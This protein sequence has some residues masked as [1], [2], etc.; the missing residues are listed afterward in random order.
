M[1]TLFV[2]HLE[3]LADGLKEDVTFHPE[4]GQ[5][6]LYRLNPAMKKSPTVLNSGY[7]KIGV[8]VNIL[9]STAVKVLVDKVR[10]EITG[11][12]FDLKRHQ[13]YFC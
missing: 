6:V 8:K 5:Y 7:F 4:E 1:E 10:H 13:F 3:Q 2:F 12:H 11:Y 9:A